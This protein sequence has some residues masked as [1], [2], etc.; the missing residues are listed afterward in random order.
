LTVGRPEAPTLLDGRW[1]VLSDQFLGPGSVFG[2]G[3]VSGD[4]QDETALGAADLLARRLSGHA[5]LPL[6]MGTGDLDMLR[7]EI[8]SGPGC[9]DLPAFGIAVSFRASE[10]GHFARARGMGV[11]VVTDSESEIFT[12]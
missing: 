3:G 5:K 7:H 2:L 10:R 8:S 6:A 4:R 1:N 12:P 11:R 9:L